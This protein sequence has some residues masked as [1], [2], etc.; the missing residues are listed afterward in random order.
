MR[1]AAAGDWTDNVR[2]EHAQSHDLSRR[3]R[4]QPVTRKLA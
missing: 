4:S 1:L 3:C 2:D